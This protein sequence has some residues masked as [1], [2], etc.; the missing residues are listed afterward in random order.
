MEK[1]RHDDLELGRIVSYWAK[2]SD[3]NASMGIFRTETVLVGFQSQG[4]DTKSQYLSALQS[5]SPS[6]SRG[7]PLTTSTRWSAYQFVL[8]DSSCEKVFYWRVRE[9]IWAF[10]LSRFFEIKNR[11]GPKPVGLTRFRFGFGFFFKKIKPVW[12]FFVGKNRT[13]PKMIT[14]NNYDHIYTLI[15]AWKKLLCWYRVYIIFI[16]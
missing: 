12:L 15:N 6:P 8:L 1:T 10:R 2:Q 5:K 9:E 7:Y 11:T 13:E 16:L 4:S 14:S 3:R